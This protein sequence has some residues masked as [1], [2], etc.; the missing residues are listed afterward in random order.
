MDAL[1]FYCLESDQYFYVDWFLLSKLFLKRVL[2]SPLRVN[3]MNHNS[4]ET[5]GKT[6]IKLQNLTLNSLIKQSGLKQL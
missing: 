2:S 1:H 4:T 5:W 6:G 3:M